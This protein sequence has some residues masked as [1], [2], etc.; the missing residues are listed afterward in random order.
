MVAAGALTSGQGSSSRTAR[1]S[2]VIQTWSRLSAAGKVRSPVAAHSSAARSWSQWRRVDQGTCFLP[3]A[4]PENGAPGSASKASQAAPSASTFW[5]QRRRPD[6]ATS[7]RARES[8]DAVR[9]SQT[10]RRSTGSMPSDPLPGNNL[11]NDL[12]G[13]ERICTVG[14]ILRLD[15]RF[16]RRPLRALRLHNYPG[17]A[18][19]VPYGGKAVLPPRRQRQQGRNPTAD[20][21]N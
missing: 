7:R 17:S 21:G 18:G 2:A 15:Y 11:L 16:N 1:P 20:V 9:S 3:P 4:K 14:R 5:S 12:V 6:R 13:P 10:G 8:S 19:E